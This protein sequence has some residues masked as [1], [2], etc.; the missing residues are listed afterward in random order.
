MP[1]DLEEVQA[2]LQQAIDAEDWPKAL[3]WLRTLQAQDPAAA[4][5]FIALLWSIIQDDRRYRQS[6]LEQ[7]RDLR[8]A[9]QQGRWTY[10]WETLQAIHAED[11]A[12]ARHVARLLFVD[13]GYFTDQPTERIAYPAFWAMLQRPLMVRAFLFG[14]GADALRARWQRQMSL[15][16]LGLVLVASLPGWLRA[17]AWTWARGL[18][19][20]GWLGLAWLLF[21]VA[22]RRWRALPW[23]AR[24]L[25]L[26]LSTALALPWAPGMGWLGVGWLVWVLEWL[27]TRAKV[28]ATDA[29]AHLMRALAWGAVLGWLVADVRAAAW[30]DALAVV[31]LSGLAWLLARAMAGR[32][33]AEPLSGPRHGG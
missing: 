30:I 15:V 19:V 20:L 5:P 32:W 3:R 21:D 8:G 23:F 16:A 25:A 27:A 17:D 7:A 11:P 4:R 29:A 6:R 24:G 10:V 13:D 9:A 28:W 31:V 26:S 18:A 1:E 2:R 12:A 22:E 14:Y 33:R